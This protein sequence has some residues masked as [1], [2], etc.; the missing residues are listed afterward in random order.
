MIFRLNRFFTFTLLFLSSSPFLLAQR[1]GVNTNSPTTTLDVNGKIRMREG[2]FSGAIM[3]SDSSGIAEWKSAD[4]LWQKKMLW[5]TDFGV[6]PNDAQDDAANIQRVL[7]SASVVGMNV[8]FPGGTYDI[9]QTLNIP[10]G[11]VMVG[12]GIGDE[13]TTAPHLGTI[14]MYEGDGWAANIIGSNAGLRDLSIRDEAGNAAGALKVLAENDAIESVQLNRV[15][16]YGFTNGTALG[17]Y[18]KNDKG[19]AYAS[20]YDFR[21]RHAK[22]GIHIHE[23]GAGFV[24]SNTFVRGVISGGGFD[25]C[26]HVQGGNNNEFLGMVIEPYTSTYGHVVVDSG[27]IVGRGVRVEGR[28]QPDGTPLVYF[29]DRTTE[30][31][32]DGFTSGG[33][34]KNDGDNKLVFASSKS[35]EVRDPGYNMLENSLFGGILDGNI[36]SW[37]ITDNRI[38]M[39]TEDPALIDR[40]MVLKLSVPPGVSGFLRP[41]PEAIPQRKE[42]KS[43]GFANFGAYIKTDKSAV[44]RATFL[45]RIGTISSIPHAGDGEWQYVGLRGEMPTAS[46]LPQIYL[47]NAGGADTAV[48]YV[49][50]PSFTFGNPLPTAEASPLTVGG[51]QLYGTLS[52][53]MIEV[54]S[55]PDHRMVLPHHANVYYIRGNN[56]IMRINELHADRFPKGTII[57]LLFQEAGVGV[58]NGAYIKML[59]SYVSKANSSL[60]LVSMG[61]GTWTEISRNL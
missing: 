14:L 8:Y 48:V 54:D 11:I 10:A 18:A 42:L 15:I 58:V 55:P 32:L 28:D 45:S 21:I 17:L 43:Q 29:A 9:D 50:C 2:A 39:E 52:T 44:A 53:N 25:R 13:P 22:T 1:V 7:D 19:I 33:Y 20:F 5:V 46:P 47:N 59:N 26:L 35:L 51:G 36:P 34:I 37:Q 40:H 56:Y 60:T 12:S 16:I 57:T 30:S 4:E 41:T 27:Q 24:N 31:Y 23:E 6:V 49:S 38:V 61:N 3:V